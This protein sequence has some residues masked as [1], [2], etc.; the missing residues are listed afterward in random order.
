[1]GRPPHQSLAERRSASH[2]PLRTRDEETGEMR[3][4]A[5][6]PY[7]SHEPPKHQVRSASE[8]LSPRSSHPSWTKL[9]KAGQQLRVRF[10][11]TSDGFNAERHGE[12]L[13]NPFHLVSNAC[14]TI[15]LYTSACS[16]SG[17]V[18]IAT[19]QKEMHSFFRCSLLY[20]AMILCKLFRFMAI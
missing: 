6:P 20:N 7:I 10:V 12:R 2:T 15:D 8:Q 4:R 16:L 17:Y 9:D 1:M 19:R 11:F 5:S 14:C 18:W 13:S 3:E